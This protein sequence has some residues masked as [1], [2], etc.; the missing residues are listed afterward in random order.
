M[1]RTSLAFVLLL[2]SVPVMAAS[3]AA[4]TAGA[5]TSATSKGGSASS[6]SSSGDSKVVK[7]ARDDAASFVASDGRIRS[8][9]LEAAL[10]HLRHHNPDVRE[11]SD[12][13][14]AQ[15]ILAL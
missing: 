4:T 13:Q 11:A 3:F 9:R 6:N 10:L 15:A 7:Q 5:G 1:I 14:L 2:A 8:A 12:L